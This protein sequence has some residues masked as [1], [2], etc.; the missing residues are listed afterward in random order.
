VPSTPAP[1]ER[2]VHFT[3]QAVVSP[4]AGGSETLRHQ[5]NYNDPFMDSGGNAIASGSRIFSPNTQVCLLFIYS[6]LFS[7]ILLEFTF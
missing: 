1:A 7:F 2:F 3:P 6:Y 5:A 4:L